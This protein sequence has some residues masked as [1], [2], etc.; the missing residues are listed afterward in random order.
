[1]HKKVQRKI[2]RRRRHQRVNPEAHPELAES[3]V[4]RSALR[5]DF[6]EGKIRIDYSSAAV[7]RRLKQVDDLR[8]ACLML[9]GP[10]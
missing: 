8:R 7:T 5:A 2:C 3:W 10:R 4:E 1:M 6:A 9:A